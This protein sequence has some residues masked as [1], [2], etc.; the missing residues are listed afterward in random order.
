M[1]S[2]NIL[3]RHSPRVLIT[4][5]LSE[6]TASGIRRS[7]NKISKIKYDQEFNLICAELHKIYPQECVCKSVYGINDL[8]SSVTSRICTL[9]E[10]F[11]M[12][13]KIWCFIDIFY[14]T[15]DAHLIL[16][17]NFLVDDDCLW[18]LCSNR[19]VLYLLVF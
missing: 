12:N 5:N 8:K 10:S 3:G 18:V 1:K 7:C 14:G 15:S 17:D 11:K 16:L 19:E 9:S 13:W 6:R 2:P 4:S